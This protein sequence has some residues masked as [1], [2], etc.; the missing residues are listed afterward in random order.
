M[1][2]RFFTLR[3]VISVKVCFI[4]VF[5]MQEYLHGLVTISEVVDDGQRLLEA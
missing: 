4:V 2:V 1:R 3:D 5:S